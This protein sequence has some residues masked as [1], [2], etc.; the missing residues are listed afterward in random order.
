MIFKSL[1]NKKNNVENEYENIEFIVSNNYLLLLSPLLLFFGFGQMFGFVSREI[2][3]TIIL[4]NY[5]LFETLKYNRVIFII[6][7]N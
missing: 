1:F 6:N 2:T 3:Q 7:H 5:N 4:S